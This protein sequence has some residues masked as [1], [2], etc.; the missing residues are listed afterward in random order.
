[1]FGR[2]VGTDGEEEEAMPAMMMM[3]WD[4]MTTSPIHGWDATRGGTTQHDAGC[5]MWDAPCPTGEVA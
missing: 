4:E 3:R 5:R 1:M 2:R